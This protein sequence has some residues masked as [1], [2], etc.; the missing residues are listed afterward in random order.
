MKRILFACDLDNTLIYSSGK[1]VD[2]DICIEKIMEKEQ[3]YISLKTVEYLKE[4]NKK[5]LFVPVT[6][7]SIEQ[8]LRINWPEGCEPKYAITT[9]GGI[10]LEDKKEAEEWKSLSSEVVK[11]YLE[12][13]DRLLKD[14]QE[15]GLFIRC[16]MVD[17]LYLFA[18]C[19]DFTDG[20]EC[21]KAYRAKTK[22]RVVLSGRKL[23]VFPEEFQKGIAVE[24]LAKMLNADTVYSAGD[25][26]IDLS[27]LLSSDQAFIPNGWLMK[28]CKDL[29]A[30]V[31]PTGVRFSEFTVE[32]INELIDENI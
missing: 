11:P 23:Y 26:I 30:N 32:K 20:K 16:R 9:N 28:E 21:E 12:E 18:Y 14:M 17:G 2:G 27:M 4:I 1:R 10:L 25:S 13:Y 24:R 7:R 6:T 31:C 3:G 22:L 15:S 5:A 19:A 29:K 8:Y